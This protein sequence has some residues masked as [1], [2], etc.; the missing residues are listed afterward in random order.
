MK[1]LILLL[2]IGSISPSFS[3]EI[4]IF[5][6]TTDVTGTTINKTIEANHDDYEM[7]FRVYNGTDHQKTIR[8]NR[9][10]QTQM[11]AGYYVLF[12]IDNLITVPSNDNLWPN[13]AFYPITMD[14]KSFL[15]GYGLTS[16][17]I[18]GPVCQDHFITYKLFDINMPNDTSTIT[19]HY[20]CTTSIHE[21]GTGI[22]AD[23]Y[24]N[25]A[26]TQVTID[27]V[28]TASPKNAKIVVYDL[29]GKVLKEVS[30]ENKEGKAFID[31]S[32]LQAGVYFYTFV[33][34][35]KTSKPGKIVIAD[36]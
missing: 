13:F 28:L 9:L 21:F 10:S 23:A 5:N 6:G 30:I 2:S 15:P 31:V 34:D 14:A 24:P 33:T 12:G 22:V 32:N 19:I 26:T 1:K 27:Y 35:S 8:Y 25:P 3:Q 17:F 7:A 16:Y 36:H 4:R 20:T 18:T 29:L 11:G